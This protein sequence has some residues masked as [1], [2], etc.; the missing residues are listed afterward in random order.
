MLFAV[1]Q[2]SFVPFSD[3]KEVLTLAVELI[4][5]PLPDVGVSIRVPQASFTFLQ[6]V[7]VGSAEILGAILIVDGLGLIY[8]LLLHEPLDQ[9]FIFDDQVVLLLVW[10]EAGP[11]GRVVGI[12]QLLIAIHFLR[13]NQRS[14]FL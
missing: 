10:L 12:R 9:L 11:A 5:F 14:L 4:S 7:C 13:N 1:D 3:R 8:V 2:F 6:A